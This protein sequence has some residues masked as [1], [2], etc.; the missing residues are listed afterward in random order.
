[1]QEQLEKAE[2]IISPKAADIRQQR[3]V[4]F[5]QVLRL[6][7]GQVLRLCSGQVLPR[8][9]E[10]EAPELLMVGLDGGWVPSREQAGGMEGKVGV[11]APT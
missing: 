4:E 2:E 3:E 1:M 5:S 6:C 7:S 9:D 8:G 11:I 10:G